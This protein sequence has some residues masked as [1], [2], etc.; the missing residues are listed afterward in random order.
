[1]SPGGRQYYDQI[2]SFAGDQY[3]AVVMA[4]L[5]HY[6]I[7]SRLAK[8]TCRMQARLALEAVKTNV[9]NSRL[10]ECLDYL[11]ANIVAGEA[12][13]WSSDFRR[14]SAGHIAW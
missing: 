2:L 14:L 7:R 5:G 13:A 3:A 8:A 9:I 12:C 4:Q 11:I 1:M 10:T 6:E